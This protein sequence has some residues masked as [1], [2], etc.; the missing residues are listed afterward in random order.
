MIPTYSTYEAKSRFSEIIRLVREGRTARVSWR[1]KP[2]AE[3]RPL[4]PEAK[5]NDEHIE[6]LTRQGVIVPSSEPPG[7]LRPMARRPGALQRFLDDRNE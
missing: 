6:E 3:I 1:G 4:P 2:V 7:F 5:S